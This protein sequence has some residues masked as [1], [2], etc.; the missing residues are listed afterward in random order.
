MLC[1]KAGIPRV[2]AKGNFTSHRAR[3]T[4]A[5]QLFNAKEPLSLFE[6]QVLKLIEI[7]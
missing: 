1:D 2:D 4:I 5:S 7:R 3:S 6:L